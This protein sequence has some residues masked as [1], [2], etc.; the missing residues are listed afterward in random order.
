MPKRN[1]IPVPIFNIV[2]H[3]VGIAYSLYLLLLFVLSAYLES[4][5]VDCEIF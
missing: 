5:L 2:F 4:V 3:D 1:Y